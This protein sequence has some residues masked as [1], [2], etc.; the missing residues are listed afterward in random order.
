VLKWTCFSTPYF[1]IY[2]KTFSHVIEK[3][4]ELIK[5][6]YSTLFQHKPLLIFH[7]DPIG[8]SR[9]RAEMKLYDPRVRVAFNKTA[10][11]DSSNL[12]DWVKKQY[13][14]ASPYFLKDQEPRLLCL[15]AFAPQMTKSLRDEFKKI[16]CTT[17]YIPGSCTGFIQVLDISLNKPLKELV[18]EQASNH[19]DK[20]YKKYTEGGFTVGDR[21]VLL[22]Q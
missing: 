21:R 5:L 12:K 8:D 22:T 7:G 19:A 16:N 3:A 17:S 10:W 2:I 1:C 15:D 4:I 6:I 20:Y 13:T 14:P 18:A 11:A 9:R